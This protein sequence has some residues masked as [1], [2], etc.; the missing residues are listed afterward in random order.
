MDALASASLFCTP[1]LQT[2][3]GI[4]NHPDPE[5]TPSVSPIL[6]TASV[7]S[8]EQP[9][10][11]RHKLGKHWHYQAAARV[12]ALCFWAVLFPYS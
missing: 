10:Q 3:Q 1:K 4:S 9:S 11:Q 7:S 6:V 5:D 8:L 2:R 12:T